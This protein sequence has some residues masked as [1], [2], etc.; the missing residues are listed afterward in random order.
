MKRFFITILRGIL[1]V[2][3]PSFGV[4]DYLSILRTLNTDDL[5]QS[6]PAVQPTGQA[7]HASAN[8]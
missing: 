7:V 5:Q 1:I 8:Q 6:L 2:S 4:S 3:T